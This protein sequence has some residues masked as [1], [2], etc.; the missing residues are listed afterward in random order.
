IKRARALQGLQ[1]DAE[2][3]ADLHA[4]LAEINARLIPSRPD[5]LLLADQGLVHVLLGDH[6]SAQVS[7][8][9]LLQI[10][11]P[12]WLTARLEAVIIKK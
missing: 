7:L 5:P 12:A 11:A 1:R 3:S 8:K 10:N 9:K 2:A 4:A 6:A